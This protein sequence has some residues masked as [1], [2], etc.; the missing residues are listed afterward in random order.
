MEEAP[1]RRQ[2]IRSDSIH[3]KFSFLR[4]CSERHINHIEEVADDR[5]NAKNGYNTH[6]QSED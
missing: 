4:I 1:R 6:R 2:P 5:Y 3:T